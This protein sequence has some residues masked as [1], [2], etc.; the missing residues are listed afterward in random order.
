MKLLKLLALLLF[1]FTTLIGCDDEDDKAT[2]DYKHG[3]F[4]I[5]EGG[6]GAANGSVSFLMPG[7]HTAEENIFKAA[8][9]DFAGDIVQSYTISGDLGYLVVNDDSKI[10][11]VTA[12]TFESVKTISHADIVKPRYI[13]IVG[14][15]AY[16]SVWGEYDENYMLTDS[17]VIVYDLTKNAVVKKID[18]DEGVE[19]LIYNGEYVFAS[20]Y[21]FGMANTLTVINPATDEIAKE[22][23]LNAGPSGMVIDT[24]GDLWVVTT[25]SFT[26]N[27]GK[28]FR[29]NSETLTVEQTIDLKSNVGGDLAI[30]SDKMNLVY[31]NDNAVYKMAIAADGPPSEPLF[32]AS[33]TT[34][35]SLSVDPATNDIYLGDALNYSSPGKIYVYNENGTFIHEIDAGINPT[36]VVFK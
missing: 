19:N 8:G 10:E 35:Y 25:G 22:L 5:N 4:I 24:N 7:S 11:V 32:Q 12:N 14:N 31:H 21:N 26:G 34:P 15:K 18:T 20:S 16:I 9:S 27:D 13:E 2:R 23:E 6:L 17:Y 28:L 1:S 33:A 30:T 36:Q 3:A 29:I